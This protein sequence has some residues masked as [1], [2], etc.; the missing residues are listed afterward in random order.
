MQRFFL[1]DS[2]AAAGEVIS[3]SSLHHQLT[4]VLR[5]QTGAKLVLL[6]NQGS[7]RLVEVISVEK[8]LAEGDRARR[9]KAGACR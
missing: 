9:D 7:E 2:L 1:P 8:G 3:L 6:D 5:V 4:R